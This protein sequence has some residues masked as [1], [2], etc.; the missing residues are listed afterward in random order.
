MM[1]IGGGKDNAQHPA[2]LSQVQVSYLA[3]DFGLTKSESSV[4]KASVNRSI[5]MRKEMLKKL[6]CGCKCFPAAGSPR[7]IAP[8]LPTPIHVQ[9]R[10]R[11]VLTDGRS[12]SIMFSTSLEEN[13][14]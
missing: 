12:A 4:Y 6:S 11:T 14:K 7:C 13:R 3:K 8:P 2:S 9:K 5:S 1:S 10:P